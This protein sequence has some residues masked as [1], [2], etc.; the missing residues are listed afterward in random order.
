M[1]ICKEKDGSWGEKVLQ[2]YPQVADNVLHSVFHNA[3]DDE[4]TA[5]ERCVEAADSVSYPVHFHFLALC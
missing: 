2:N 1:G 5:R 4:K 3:L